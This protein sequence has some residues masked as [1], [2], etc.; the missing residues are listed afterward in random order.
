M[1]KPRSDTVIEGENC[2]HCISR[3]VRRAFLHGKDSYT[4]KNY[5]HRKEW[6]RERLKF[7]VGVFCIEVLACALMDNHLHVMIRTCP[8]KLRELSDCDVARLWLLLYPKSFDAE[9]IRKQ[10]EALSRNK[11]QIK[12]LRERLGS[13]SWFMKSISEFIARR[14]NRE[15][16]CKGR[17]WE[18]R[19]RCQRLHG[20]ASLL[21][22]AVYIDLNPVRAGI[23]K[24]PEESKFTSARERIEALRKGVREDSLW[25]AP[26]LS[27]RKRRGFLSIS[28]KEYLVVLD[29]AGRLIKKGKKG[30][31]PKDSEP[32][33]KRLGIKPE[34]WAMLVQNLGNA[35]SCVVGPKEQLLEAASSL[36]RQWLKGMNLSQKAFA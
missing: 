11:K 10:I 28:F 12:I 3:C 23:A 14:A 22:C 35:F 29:E 36:G 30:A 27:T 32:I 34:G 18:G 25:L 19:F 13:V 1:T 2:Y 20:E 9:I 15:D 24:T 21:G 33:L 16:D 26:T 8:E 7:L 31:I 4:G 6:I 5:D 17:F